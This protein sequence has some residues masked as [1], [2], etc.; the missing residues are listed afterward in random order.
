MFCKGNDVHNHE[1]LENIEDIINDDRKS[2][3]YR[4]ESEPEFTKVLNIER[5]GIGNYQ[6]WSAVAERSRALDSSSGV[7]RMWVR[8][9]TWRL[10]P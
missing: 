3:F 2:R 4:T 6:P 5:E 8:I 9:L 10:C 1:S 7:V